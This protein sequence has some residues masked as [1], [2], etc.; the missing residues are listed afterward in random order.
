[1]HTTTCEGGELSVS[2]TAWPSLGSSWVPGGLSLEVPV[3]VLAVGLASN[4][5]VVMFVCVRNTQVSLVF[6]C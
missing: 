2:T 3:A 6:A 1:M 4:E 5:C